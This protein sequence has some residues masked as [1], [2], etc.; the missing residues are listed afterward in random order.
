MDIL[1]DDAETLILVDEDD[2]VI[3]PAGKLDAHRRGDL[4]RAFS[5]FVFRTNGDLL[6][7]QRASVKYHSS[8]KWAN[9]CCGHPRPGEDVLAAA[10]RRLEEETGLQVPLE[11]GFKARYRADLDN[12]MIENELVHVVFGVSD[13]PGRITPTEVSAYRDIDLDSLG[14]EIEA[15]PNRFAVW[16]VKYF[17]RHSA[18][19]HRQ[20]DRILD[21][22]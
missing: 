7:Q 1:A 18:L 12:G 11:D 8:G 15:H 19:I 9:T 20:R 2:T 3:A 17:Q 4:H 16:L 5:V 14:R 13:A 21:G 6:I 10:R 22:L